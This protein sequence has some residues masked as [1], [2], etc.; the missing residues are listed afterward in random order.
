MTVE[1]STLA[2]AEGD[3]VRRAHLVKP[4]TQSNRAAL[5]SFWSALDLPDQDSSFD[6]QAWEEESWPSFRR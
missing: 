4:R 1:R 6:G 3:E 2:R 5:I